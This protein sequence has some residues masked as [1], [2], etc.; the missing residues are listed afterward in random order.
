MSADDGA[1][2]GHATRE[3]ILAEVVSVMQSFREGMKRDFA[4]EAMPEGSL[5]NS[6]DFL[7][8]IISSKLRK[9][10][11][12]VYAS[13]DLN[14]VQ[15]T[16][17]QV[18]S[19][20]WAPFTAGE[21]ILVFDE[22][23]RVYEIESTVATENIG[24]C[25]ITR[26]P[27]FYTDKVIVPDD[28]RAAIP[29]KITRSAGTHT[30]ADLGGTPPS[31]RHAIIYKDVC[32]L[33]NTSANPQRIF[34]STAGN[35]EATWDTTNKFLDSSFPITGMKALS[36]AVFVFS[37]ARTMRVRGSIPPPDSDF[38]VDDPIFEVGCTDNRSIC[39][40]KDK[41]IWANAQGLYISDG[42]SLEDLTRV[43]GMKRWWSDVLAG[44][45]GFTLG[46]TYSPS[47]WSITCSIF[48][49]DLIYSIMD[50][51]NIKDSGM[52]DL[53]RY[54][55]FR[56]SGIDA[57]C[58]FHRPYPEEVFWGRRNAA[59]LVTTTSMLRPSATNKA[60]ATG[61]AVVPSLETPFFMP[62]TGIQSMRRVY[63]TYLMTDAG[64]DN[65]ILTVSHVT[66]PESTSYTSL[67]PTLVESTALARERRALHLPA[68]GIGFKIAQS[69]A[70]ADT[71]I[72]DIA[73]EAYGRSPIR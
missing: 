33:G 68:R 4:R 27:V 9:R 19:G 55:W 13:Q 23:G 64:S 3:L 42:S 36:N 71:R 43:C 57:L 39:D 46:G 35:P 2:S 65:P 8:E 10:G 5:W 48:G 73:L 70:S 28:T 40:Y 20:L 12:F 7:P 29:K 37:L 17:T 45:E 14:A 18:A 41:V 52:I 60:D 51:T 49:D 11:G 67:T 58:M 56:H 31:A 54:S 53:A 34:F 26:S 69:N 66:S 47:T 50:G 21:S 25:R 16:A 30:V 32:W 59:R 24:A 61:T 22:D 15:A 1:K 63:V 72:F 44:L 6:V 62:D 38:I